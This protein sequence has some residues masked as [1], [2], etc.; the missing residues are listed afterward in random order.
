MKRVVVNT[1]IPLTEA[2]YSALVKIARHT[3]CDTWFKIRQNSDGTYYV[4]D[5]EN[6]EKM[7]FEGA[8]M[9]LSDSYAVTSASDCRLSSEEEK[10]WNELRKRADAC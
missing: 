2:E 8:I 3:G 10:A 5:R 4:F 9:L 6:D 1:H 7:S